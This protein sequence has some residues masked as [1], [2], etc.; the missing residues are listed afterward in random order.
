MGGDHHEHNRVVSDAVG[1]AGQERVLHS[2]HPGDQRFVEPRVHVL[3]AADEH[4]LGAPEQRE[5]VPVQAGQVP[6][7]QLRQRVLWQIRQVAERQPWAAEEEL[8]PVEAG[9]H[10][11]DQAPHPVSAVRPGA[12]RQLFH[13]VGDGNRQDL[14]HAVDAADGCLREALVHASQQRFE[15]GGSAQREGLQPGRRQLGAS[16]QA[17]QQR[18]HHGGDGKEH[19][20]L[21]HQR[22]VALRVGSR[23]RPVRGECP[24]GPGDERRHADHQLIRQHPLPCLQTHA[25]GEVCQAGAERAARVRDRAG[26][27]RGA[28]REHHQRLGRGIRLALQPAHHGRIGRAGGQARGVERR[29]RCAG[30]PGAGTDVPGPGDEPRVARKVQAAAAG[31]GAQRRAGGQVEQRPGCHPSGPGQLGPR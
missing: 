20:R 3:G 18:V 9:A 19:L 12:R 24:M 16:L 4:V 26:L 11:G 21:G 2:L 13:A 14:R 1:D 15:H 5:L 17:A 28:A 10:A 8:V 23:A 29:R 22:E 31:Q 7:A 27:R 25:A 6:G 30:E